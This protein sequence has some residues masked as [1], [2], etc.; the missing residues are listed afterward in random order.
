MASLLEISIEES[1][2]CVVDL[3]DTDLDWDGCTID[4]AERGCFYTINRELA[5][6]RRRSPK[7]WTGLI[8]NNALLI[9]LGSKIETFPGF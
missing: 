4:S 6:P 5:R 3:L 8:A 9:L 1:E 2:G 7:T